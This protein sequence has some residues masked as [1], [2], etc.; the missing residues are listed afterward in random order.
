ML[1]FSPGYRL[2]PWLSPVGDPWP[3]AA[4]VEGGARGPHS[5]SCPGSMSCSRP[6]HSVSL[7][8]AAAG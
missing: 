1:S 5:Q 2:K 6:R 7:V 3:R 4:Q 8:S